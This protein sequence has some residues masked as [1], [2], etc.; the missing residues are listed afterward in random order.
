MTSF[1][2]TVRGFLTCTNLSHLIQHLDVGSQQTVPPCCQ[3]Y[4]GFNRADE[5]P[6]LAKSLPARQPGARHDGLR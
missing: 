1:P 4:V 5:T 2:L 6:L 3:S